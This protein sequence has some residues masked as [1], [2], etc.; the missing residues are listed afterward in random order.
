MTD[1]FLS[2]TATGSL[3]DGTLSIFGAT[4]G[5]ENLTPNMALKTSI[6][7]GIVSSN[8]EI[9]DTN[10]L[11]DAL[12][13]E[14]LWD[15]ATTTISPKN[16]GD[17]LD[18]VDQ[19]VT[20]SYTP[21]D[22]VD[23]TNKLYVDTAVAVENI[24]NR[25]DPDI[26]LNDNTDVVCLG[27]NTDVTQTFMTY[28]GD[29]NYSK[30]YVY[31]TDVAGLGLN[32]HV[33]ILGAGVAQYQLAFTNEGGGGYVIRHNLNTQATALYLLS[34]PADS[35]AT[36]RWWTIQKTA[37][38]STNAWSK[39]YFSG[40]GTFIYET[41]DPTTGYSW[42][43]PTSDSYIFNI[44]S[45]PEA[46]LDA[47]GLD[48]V[49]DIT[50]PTTGSL[51]NYMTYIGS[52][53]VVSGFA[54]TDVGDGT[55]NIAQGV[56]YLRSS[57]SDTAGLIEYTV[58][59]KNALSLTDNSE[60]TVYIDYNAGTPDILNTVTSSTVT[61]NENNL[62]EIYEIIRDGND[63]TIT[64]HFQYVGNAMKRA[65]IK[66]YAIYGHQ[67]ASGLIISDSADT[68]RN[69]GVT[70]GVIW[71]KFNEG[72]ISAIDTSGA[73]TFTRYYTSDSGANWTKQTAQTQWDNTNYN[74]ITS[75]LV[76]MTVNRYAFQD[77]WIGGDGR[78]LSLFSQ[79]QYNSRAGAENANPSS[80][81]PHILTVGHSIF[82]GRIVYQKSG[83]DAVSTLSV[84]TTTFN[85]AVVTS[86]GDLSDLSVDDHSIYVTLANRT[87]ETL[88]IDNITAVG[89]IIVDNSADAEIVI[90][91]GSH[92]T[93]EGV[94]TYKTANITKFEV[95]LRDDSTNDYHIWRSDDKTLLKFSESTDI[96]TMLAQ[97]FEMQSASSGGTC[98]FIIDS[99]N[100][101]TIRTQRGAVTDHNL[102]DFYT[103]AA[104]V[105]SVG[106]LEDSEDLT[107][108]RTGGGGTETVM[109]FD[110]A[111]D[112]VE[113]VTGSLTVTGNI[114][115]NSDGSS[116]IES[117]RASNV[118]YNAITRYSTG[119]GSKWE[120]GLRPDASDDLHIW[121]NDDVSVMRFDHAANEIEIKTNTIDATPTTGAMVL[122]LKS[123]DNGANIHT[124]RGDTSDFSGLY[125]ESGGTLTWQIG[126][127]NDASED[128][129]IW[130]NGGAAGTKICMTFDHAADEVYFPTVYETTVT[131]AR[132]LEI[133]SDGLIGYVSSI[134]A[135]K[136][137]ITN[138]TS[139]DWLYQLA[140]KSFNYRVK[141][142]NGDFTDEAETTQQYGLLAEDM[143]L[144]ND[145]LCIYDTIKDHVQDCDEIECE[146]QG[147][148]QQLCGIY[149][150]KLITPMLHIIKQQKS[151]IDALS[152]RVSQT[153]AALI[154][155]QN[156]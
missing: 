19:K 115:S 46:T 152:I 31:D 1:R 146:C 151:L 64:P 133:Q 77:F 71:V 34:D 67:R 3:S 43:I 53:G 51:Q 65:N 2:G 97:N 15:R 18:L 108:Y 124:D 118:I 89:T 63:L 37:G 9:S 110:H 68:N 36:S 69:V 60:N 136:I 96:V 22:N 125:L 91:R 10:G 87:G 32:A 7:S 122:T 30:T 119:G 17:D 109:R 52:A 20:T 112:E 16:A 92:I 62:I 98:T 6:L 44:N 83:A 26:T 137:N 117:D 70:A 39:Q 114:I 11:Q 88:N 54:I 24:W 149:Y 56:A 130:R 120:I 132:D 156:P 150:K 76:D 73:D 85:A 134:T 84:F 57:N 61:D 40:S 104:N 153:E 82:I 144:V 28:Q 116:M 50:M 147:T 41:I 80:T 42:D 66:D 81:V 106:Q 148:H 145:N 102:I 128:L 127:R 135:A 111:A 131:S 27:T 154:S 33:Q 126:S 45:T 79:A 47:T 38:N 123:V 86:H 103:A 105:W 58:S 72:S 90:D 59:A 21:V 29:Q 4:L 107:I 155:L 121:R 101:A 14:N 94:L 13:T 113:I 48:I 5:A 143:Q 99:E 100:D 25:S 142:A 129:H 12:D 95:G 35:L 49:T 140:P 139:S 75:G 23:L 93:D 141:D 55:V 74:D 8:L 138:I 78:L